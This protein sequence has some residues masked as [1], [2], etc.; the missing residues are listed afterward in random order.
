MDPATMKVLGIPAYILFWVAAVVCFGIFGRRVIGL[1][2]LLR[3]ARPDYR[4]DHV[5]TRIRNVIVH[6]LGQKR[7]LEEPLIGLA[8]LVIFWT[9]LLYAGAF[10]WSLARG[11]LP[12]LPIP[13]P[14][15]VTVVRM[16]METLG[17]LTLVAITVAAVRRFFFAP[18]HLQRTGTPI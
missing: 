14:D 16:L 15:E 3:R 12:F 5:P 18:P 1:V 7:L 4:F 8:H 17:I 13:Y 10:A 6:V 2:R 11:L 9:F